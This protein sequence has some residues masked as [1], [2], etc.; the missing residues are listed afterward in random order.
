MRLFSYF[1]IHD[2]SLLIIVDPINGLGGGGGRRRDGGGG[3][4]GIDEY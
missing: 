2:E 3:G 4:G 1:D